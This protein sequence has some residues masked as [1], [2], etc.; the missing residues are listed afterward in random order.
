MNKQAAASSWLSQKA[1]YRWMVFSRVIA[2]FIGGYILTAYITM[3][4]AQLFPM[5]RADAVVLASLL[6]Y[7]WFCIAIIWVFA[8]KSAVK[9]WLGILGAIALFA[10]IHYS[11]KAFG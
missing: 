11:I 9:A 4:L 6:S 7:L 8:V 3:V 2:G 5:S 10:A 1:M